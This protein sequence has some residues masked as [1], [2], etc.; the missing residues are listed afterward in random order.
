MSYRFD[1]RH[2]VTQDDGSVVMVGFADDEFEPTHFVILQKAHEYDEQDTQ[3]GMDK[4]HISVAD[5]SRAKYGGIDTVQIS[6]GVVHI[7]LS[8]EAKS[9]LSI[10][11]AIEVVCT[12]DHADFEEAKLQ[13]RKMCEADGIAFAS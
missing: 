8:D 11:G 13:L 3:T 1:A 2:I 4:I 10:D 6:D 7:A 12:A 9:A 5:G